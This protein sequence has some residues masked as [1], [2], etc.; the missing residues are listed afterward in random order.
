MEHADAAAERRPHA[1]AEAREVLA[2]VAGLPA[3]H[4][5]AIMLVDVVGLTYGEAASALGVPR[6]TIMSRLSRGRSAVINQLAP[7]AA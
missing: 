5:D 4:R 7:V 2:A 1:T 6:G 3:G